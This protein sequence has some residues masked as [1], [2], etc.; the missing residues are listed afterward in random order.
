AANQIRGLLAEFG[1]ILPQGIKNVTTQVAP[2][3]EDNE[4]DLPGEFRQL[5]LLLVEH[6]KLLNERVQQLDEQILRWHRSSQASMRLAEIPGVGVLTASAMVASVGDARHFKGGKQLAA[7]LGLAPRQHSSGGQ[8]HMLCLSKRGDHYLRTLL[9]HGAR[10][11]LR[12]TPAR[13]DSADWSERILARRHKNIACVAQA[14]KTARI[15]WALLTHDRRFR[16]DYAYAAAT[17]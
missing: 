17:A 11:K 3:L 5:M 10:A 4:Q 12:C 7:W 13:A 15:I 1:I 14:H 16:H 9:V 2:I 6:F 8:T